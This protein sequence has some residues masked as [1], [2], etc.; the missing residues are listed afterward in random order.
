MCIREDQDFWYDQ[1]ETFPKAVKR[2]IMENG[3]AAASVISP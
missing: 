1:T 2:H 3:A